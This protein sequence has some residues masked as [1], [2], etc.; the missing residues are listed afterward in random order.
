VVQLL[1]KAGADALAKALD[2]SSAAEMASIPKIKAL[3]EE[4]A[5]RQST[6]HDGFKNAMGDDDDE[7]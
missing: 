1:L 5:V 2:G 4:A 7:G 3:L 6:M